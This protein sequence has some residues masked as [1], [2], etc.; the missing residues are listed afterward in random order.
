MR[1]RPERQFPPHEPARF[2]HRGRRPGQD[3]SGHH[4]HAAQ[5]GAEGD[6]PEGA[7]RLD[8]RPAG[9]QRRRQVDLHQHPGRPDA[10]RPSGTVRIWGRDIDQRPRDAR[11]A[12][13]VVPQEIAADVFFTPRESL[14]VQAG[15]YGVPKKRAAHRRAAGRPGP[16]RQGQRLCAPA[17][18]RHEAAADGGQGHGAQP[19]GA[20]PGR[21]HRR[22]RRRAA[23][24]AVGLCGAS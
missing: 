11:A 5:G 7:A 19:A 9:P 12:I 6:R 16:G 10:A 14:E 18:G 17:V 1:T 8:L 24:P 21:A 3:L 20:D 15:L 13:G 2:R 4:D 23:P 22:G